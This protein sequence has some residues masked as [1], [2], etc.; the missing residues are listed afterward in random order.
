MDAKAEGNGFEEYRFAGAA[1]M[2][3]VGTSASAYCGG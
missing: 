3:R 2:T 1:A